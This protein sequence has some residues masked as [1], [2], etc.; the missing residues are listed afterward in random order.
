VGATGALIVLAPLAG[1]GRGGG[2]AEKAAVEGAPEGS[3]AA[4]DPCAD[5][6]GI[7]PAQQEFRDDAGYVAETPNPGERCDNCAYWEAPRGGA[8]CGGCTAIAGP[9]HPGGWCDLWEEQT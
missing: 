2:E 9:I 1:C 8:A 5:L 4:T 3:A 6:S 7:T